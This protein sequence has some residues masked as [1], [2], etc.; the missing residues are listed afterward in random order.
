MNQNFADRLYRKVLERQCPCVVGL[1]PHLGALPPEFEAVHDP[2][3]TRRERAKAVEAFLCGIIE[4]VADIVPAVK[5]QSAFFEV[6]GADGALVWENV[7]KHAHQ[8]GLLVVGDVKRGDIGSTAA[9]YAQAFLTGEPGC[10]RETLCD[11]ITVNP[12]LGSD[13]IDPFLDACRQSGTGLYILVRTS[14]PSSAEFQAQGEP[15]LMDRVADAVVRWG[16]DLVGDCGYS[17]IG[18]VVG[19]THPAEL[20]ACARMPQTP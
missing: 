17:S 15:P 5:P 20:N 9:A 14:N 18:A 11:C 6:L 1:D 2:G 19:A 13:S 10:D 8:A 7:V 16:S 12:Y 4:A 3:S